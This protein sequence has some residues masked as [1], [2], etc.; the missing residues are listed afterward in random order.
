MDHLNGTK[1]GLR[2]LPHGQLDFLTTSEQV[3]LVVATVGHS[4]DPQVTR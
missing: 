4:A 3:G 1:R 2:M